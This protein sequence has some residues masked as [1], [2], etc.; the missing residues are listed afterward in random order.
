MFSK[1][2]SR[3]GQSTRRTFGRQARSRGASHHRVA[4]HHLIDCTPSHWSSLG[5]NIRISQEICSC[6]HRVSCELSKDRFSRAKQDCAPLVC[7]FFGNDA[8]CHTLF[9]RRWERQVVSTSASKSA[10]TNTQKFHQ[11]EVRYNIRFDPLVQAQ[12]FKR[13]FTVVFFIFAVGSAAGYIVLGAILLN[14][15]NRLSQLPSFFR[16]STSQRQ[17][18]P[19]AVEYSK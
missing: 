19:T 10:M 7:I 4:S 1:H 2:W 18:A 17:R 5:H 6:Q 14:F 9:L 8:D 11:V 13:D 16:K 15:A 3:F 12:T